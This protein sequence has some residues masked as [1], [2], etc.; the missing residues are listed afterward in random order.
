MH[1]AW[2]PFTPFVFYSHYF[3]IYRLKQTIPITSP[4]AVFLW[5]VAVRSSDRFPVHRWCVHF[6]WGAQTVHSVAW[7]LWLPL[8]LLLLHLR[9][10]RYTKNNALSL[11]GPSDPEGGELILGRFAVGGPT[12]IRLSAILVG[13]YYKRL[14]T[15]TNKSRNQSKSSPPGLQSL[16]TCIVRRQGAI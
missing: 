11:P 10:N 5:K 3:V 4:C 13:K 9:H 16:V 2:A 15:P 14:K 8:L 1:W 12:S 6:C 7:K